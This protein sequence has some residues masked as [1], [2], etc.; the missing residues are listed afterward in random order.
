MAV[1]SVLRYY[2]G[3][4]VMVVTT[5]VGVQYL[6]QVGGDGTNSWSMLGD[7]H[8]WTV[9]LFTL[10]WALL[11]LWVPGKVFSGPQ[12][13]FGYTPVYKANGFQFFLVSLAAFFLL[14]TCYPY[15]SRD[16]FHNFQNILASC[17]I[18]AFVLC[19]YLLVKGKK[20]PESTE[21]IESKPLLYEFY[22]GMEL[23]PRLLGVDV[24]QLTNCRFG[25]LAWELL[26]V[27]FFLAGWEKNGFSMGHLVCA[28]LQT[29][30]LGKFFWWE[31]GYFNTLDII[32]DRAGYYICW[33]CLVF[34]PSLYT[35]SSYYLVAHPPQVSASTATLFFIL[36]VCAILLNYRI[37]WEKEHFRA[38]DGKCSLWGRPVTY[39]EAQYKSAT[40]H[41]YSKLLTSGSWGVARHLNYTLELLLSLAWCLPGLGY[42][43]W[44]FLYVIFLTVLLVH[45]VF[46][47]EEKC[48]AK[49]GSAWDKYCKEVPYRMIPRVF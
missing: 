41:K 44:P 31:T 49:Y 42:G 45:R 18:L 17:N 22:R 47:D 5:C 13:H 30:Y 34:V 37:D 40:G 46:R 4:P 39:I 3:P 8:S 35:Y 32:L 48:R 27:S 24:K 16:I 6:A 14:V 2:V 26:V 23:H 20:W 9:V 28:T 25:L 15:V 33:G 7:A 10:L 12:T 36:G 11:S 29:I 1:Y 21:A 19:I 43:V 38:H